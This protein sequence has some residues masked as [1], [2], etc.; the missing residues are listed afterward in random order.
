MPFY[1]G[2]NYD[3]LTVS[4]LH[5]GYCCRP[6]VC[7]NFQLNIDDCALRWTEAMQAGVAPPV[8]LKATHAKALELISLE[9]LRQY[10]L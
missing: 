4:V 3:L 5:A 1:S 6:I 9:Q 8:D 2:L 7:A 10:A